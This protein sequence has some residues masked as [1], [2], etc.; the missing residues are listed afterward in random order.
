MNLAKLFDEVKAQKGR[1]HK[2]V[3]DWRQKILNN[4]TTAPDDWDFSGVSDNT[5][6][7]RAQFESQWMETELNYVIQPVHCTC[8]WQHDEHWGVFLREEHRNQR[9][10]IRHTR[11]LK[12]LEQFRHLPRK[13]V[14]HEPVHCVACDRC[15]VE[16][17]PEQ[18]QLP[19][20]ELSDVELDGI[21]A[22]VEAAVAHATESAAFKDKLASQYATSPGPATP[23]HDLEDDEPELF[24]RSRKD[25]T[26]PV[27]EVLE[28]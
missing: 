8:G 23:D 26:K 1:V 19:I 15:F 3:K 22:G 6:V 28:W 17:G 7:K 24:T 18:L 21:V 10:T 4:P 27:D 16:T 13:V 5:I 14:T 9:G 2:P 25:R 11:L 12:N 20:N